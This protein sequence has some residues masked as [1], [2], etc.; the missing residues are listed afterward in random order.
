MPSIV[1]EQI[2]QREKLRLSEMKLRF[3]SVRSSHPGNSQVEHNEMQYTYHLQIVQ[4]ECTR[5]N[6]VLC[7][8]RAAIHRL[9]KK[10]E[11]LEC[12]E[13]EEKAEWEG[14]IESLVRNEAEDSWEEL[15]GVVGVPLC[16]HRSEIGYRYAESC[17]G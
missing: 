9:E 6:S 17:S 8:K 1:E 10:K 5:L 3:G 13:K 11:E 4:G 2:L 15:N 16:V 7:A 14:V 12:L